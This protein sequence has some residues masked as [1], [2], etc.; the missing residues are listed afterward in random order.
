MLLPGAR[1][2]LSEPTDVQAN[3]SR[4]RNDAVPRTCYVSQDLVLLHRENSVPIHCQRFKLHQASISSKF[5]CCEQHSRALKRVL[6]CRQGA[7]KGCGAAR[8]LLRSVES[9]SPGH[10]K[11]RSVAKV[12]ASISASRSV[13][14]RNIDN[15]PIAVAA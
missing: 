4:P 9:P 13:P 14:S 3:L 10:Q 5:T 7:A 6:S 2:Y 1:S 15:A 11:S 12:A 8:P